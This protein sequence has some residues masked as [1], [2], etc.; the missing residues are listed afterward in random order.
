MKDFLGRELAV[1]DAVATNRHG[2]TDH[3]QKMYV[4]DFTPKKIKLSLGS[5]IV[6][7]YY[8]FPKQVVKI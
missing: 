8:K 4:V 5:S 3:L 1:G 6:G 7:Y 2:Y